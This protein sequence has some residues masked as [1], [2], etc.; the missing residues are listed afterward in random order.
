MAAFQA[1]QQNML[2][3]CSSRDAENVTGSDLGEIVGGEAEA[4]VEDRNVE[5]PF[6]GFPKIHG[7]RANMK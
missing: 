2:L 7:L 4:S 6:Q 3:I 1:V 5:K